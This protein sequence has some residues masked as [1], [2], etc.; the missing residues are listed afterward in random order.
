MAPSLTTDDIQSPKPEDRSPS[1]DK[2]PAAPRKRGWLLPVGLLALVGLCYGV[3][4]YVQSLSREST[5]DAFV[6]GTVVQV[7]PRVSG[8]VTNLYIRDNQHVKKD[9]LLLEIDSRDLQNA[10]DQ[11]R[12]AL[13]SAQARLTAAEVDVATIRKTAS[14]AVAQEKASLERANA[15]AQTAHTHVDYAQSMLLQSK[16]RRLAAIAAIEQAK[17]AA[18]AA[19]A[20]ATRAAADQQRYEALFKAGGASASQRD[21]FNTAAT[22]AAAEARAAQRKIAAAE[23][24]LA[25]AE[26]GEQTAADAVRQAQSDYQAS[27]ARIKEQE[28][29]LAGVDVAD[30]RLARAQAEQARAAADVAQWNA[31]VKQAELD[32]SYTKVRAVS[33]GVVT[34]KAVEIGNYVRAGQAL[35]GLVSDEKWVIA[36]FKETQLTHVKPGQETII[37]VDAYPG[38]RLKARVDSIQRGTG[39]RFSLLPAENATGNFVKVVQ[40]VPVKLVFDDRLPEDHPLSLGMSVIPEIHIK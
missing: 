19:D 18:E 27:L 15:D 4:A 17:A 6:D 40:R 30:E 9:D 1:L 29:R 7:S 14:A 5:D 25:E 37:S 2:T 32:F 39:A 33:D 31:T 28:S 38:L 16:A 24:Q 35:L 10:L 20:E 22:S 3:Y 13:A 12:G 11:A 34:K 36:N 23:A 21:Q 8:Y 26:A